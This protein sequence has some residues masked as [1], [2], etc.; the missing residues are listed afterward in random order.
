M[1]SLQQKA[2]D[3]GLGVGTVTGVS[4]KAIPRTDIIVYET[5]IAP[6]LSQLHIGGSKNNS[7][8]KLTLQLY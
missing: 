5:D 4:L 6:A 2:V 8:M 1:P 7:Y 3:E